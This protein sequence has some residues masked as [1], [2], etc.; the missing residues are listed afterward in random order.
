M[1]H[2]ECYGGKLALKDLEKKEKE[3][4][5]WLTCSRCGGGKH[6]IGDDILKV[7]QT[8]IDGKERM[9]YETESKNF[10]VRVIQKI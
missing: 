2:Q 8:A 10:E 6:L 5:V 9:V 7:V 3:I 1:S 4:S